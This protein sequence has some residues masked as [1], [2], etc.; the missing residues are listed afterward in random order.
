M[1]DLPSEPGRTVLADLDAVG[2]WLMQVM[3]ESPSVMARLFQVERHLLNG[4]KIR[5]RMEFH[6]VGV[7]SD[8][9][10]D[11]HLHLAIGGRPIDHG[12]I[13]ICC[14]DGRFFKIYQSSPD[15]EG[16]TKQ[17]CYFA[18]A[19]DAAHFL[20]F[21]ARGRA[22]RQGRPARVFEGAM[23]EQPSRQ[24]RY[25][26]AEHRLATGTNGAGLPISTRPRLQR[27]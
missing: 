6:Y 8:G 24:G 11:L 4:A 9:G 25:A 18:G 5:G 10:A 26:P 21:A 15:K 3:P 1:T 20:A 12:S 22:L 23:A 17:R 16:Q 14:A 13:A 27:R 19:D 7:L 2:T